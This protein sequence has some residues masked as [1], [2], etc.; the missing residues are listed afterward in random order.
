MQ[1]SIIE[2]VG[3]IEYQRGKYYCNSGSLHC[4]TYTEEFNQPPV[5]GL[6]SWVSEHTQGLLQ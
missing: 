2:I 3:F 5:L 4:P 1:R 6:L